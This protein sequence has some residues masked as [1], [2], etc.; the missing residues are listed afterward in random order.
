MLKCT[1]HE[2]RECI[3]KKKL[4][5]ILSLVMILA[6]GSM[7]AFATEGS[8]SPT[9][10]D[11]LE[12][13]TPVDTLSYGTGGQGEE[14]NV[15]FYD[16]GAIVVESTNGNPLLLKTKD[17]GNGGTV[18]EAKT[19]S[20]ETIDIDV[21]AEFL[22]E[23]PKEVIGLVAAQIASTIN[24]KA[25]EYG[26][27]A[28]AVIAFDYEGATDE[29]GNITIKIQNLSGDDVVYVLHYI[30]AEQRWE[31]VESEVSNGTLTIIGSTGQSPFIIIKFDRDV[32]GE[33]T[34][35]YSTQ[36]VTNTV[37]GEV[38]PKTADTEPYAAMI[39]MI[40]LACVT[41]FARKLAKR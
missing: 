17:N 7:T 14:I 41:V 10:Q 4:F 24:S 20:G 18:I 34:V 15:H 30:T 40:S 3:M 35:D 37:S 6:M 27:E 38:S 12:T 1:N 25:D 29:N 33:S 21:P 39:A 19:D 9:A 26:A 11:Y 28:K 13:L 8:N 22:Q 16:D 5:A 2:R 36:S 23:M 32:T 31:I